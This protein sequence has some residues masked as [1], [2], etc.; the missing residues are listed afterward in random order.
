[1]NEN[2]LK[3]KKKYLKYKKKYYMVKKLKGGLLAT[4]YLNNNNCKN[5]LYFPKVCPEEYPCLDNNGMCYDNINQLTNE[6]KVS[7]NLVKEIFS[8]K[9]NSE[10]KAVVIRLNSSLENTF[11]FIIGEHIL[12]GGE[13]SVFRIK[14]IKGIKLDL[15]LKLSIKN[16]LKSKYELNRSKL[17]EELKNNYD[18]ENTSLMND[19]KEKKIT[20]EKYQ[21]LLLEFENNSKKFF[22]DKIMKIP[23]TDK[24]KDYNSIKFQYSL[25]NEPFINQIIDFGRYKITIDKSYFNKVNLLNPINCEDKDK[26]IKKNC[27]PIKS[28]EGSYQI[29]KE[30]KGDDLYIVLI[31]IK[32]IN[33]NYADNNLL[34]RN[35]IKNLLTGLK[36]IH[37]KGV[38][39]LDIKSQNIALSN[40]INYQ[41]I[42]SEIDN[43]AAIEILDF[44]LANRVGEESKLNGT[45]GYFSPDFQSIMHNNGKKLISFKDDIYSMGILIFELVHQYLPY[46]GEVIDYGENLNYLID[47]NEVT[48]EISKT[49]DE[50]PDEPLFLVCIKNKNIH[51]EPIKLNWIEDNT[52]NFNLSNNLTSF[53]ECNRFLI[54]SKEHIIYTPVINQIN[55][56]NDFQLDDQ[57]IDL[58]SKMLEI[59]EENRFD[60]K[61]ALEH[62]YLKSLEETEETTNPP[63][64]KIKIL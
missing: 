17:L 50:E 23:S 62:P 2:D 32:N 46:Q 3:F 11:D 52:F 12:S 47:K 26:N 20:K 54:Y 45:P 63:L 33:F 44:G 31:Q 51:M 60:V 48:I 6:P 36:S 19:L 1:M 34:L 49:F 28:F 30:C 14:N 55:L 9:L 64:K 25:R 38:A 35:I 40:K 10:D 27:N 21:T 59:E 29:V 18:Q 24:Y 15:L 58:L 42:N 53:K 43:L 8:T 7:S 57:F 5:R 56:F 61:Q 22:N 41:N 37:D 16:N 13:S 4:S 39:H